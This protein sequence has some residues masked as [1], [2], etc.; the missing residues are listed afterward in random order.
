MGAKLLTYIQHLYRLLPLG[1]I[2]R[3]RWQVID[4]KRDEMWRKNLINLEKL[5][6]A[7]DIVIYVIEDYLGQLNH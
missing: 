7:F 1:M 6:D 4:F 2:D 3:F 5:F